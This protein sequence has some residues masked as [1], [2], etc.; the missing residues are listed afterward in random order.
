[1]SQTDRVAGFPDR[2]TA[3]LRL[4]GLN[5]TELCARTG[6]PKSA[7]SQYLHGRFAPRDDRAA[8]LARALGVS[9]AWLLGYD[10]GM[11]REP[12]LPDGAMPLPLGVRIPVL[13][14][15]AAGLPLYAE[16]NIEGY[17]YGDCPQGESYF[18]LRV[19]GDSMTA[20]G[21]ANG[22]LVVVRQQNTVDDN[23]IAVV[24]VNGCEA[25][26]KRFHRS[27]STV[28][29]TPQSYNPTHQ[30]Q[31]YNLKDTPVHIYGKVVEVRHKL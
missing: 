23:E 5:Q 20:A 18:A 31:F 4:R 10:V 19:Q 28:V 3:A 30:A 22:D 1:M 27:G 16:E 15:V 21:I 29:L 13:G 17:L 7:L 12:A 9:E 25:T 8:A 11:E 6:V 24:C 2:L 26:V 14:R